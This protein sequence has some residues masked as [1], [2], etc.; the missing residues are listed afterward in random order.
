VCERKDKQAIQRV[1]WTQ[2]LIVIA[3]VALAVVT[4]MLC[5]ANFNQAPVNLFR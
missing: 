5:K 2:V 4:F 3:F 1:S